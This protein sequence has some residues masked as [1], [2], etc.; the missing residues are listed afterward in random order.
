MTIEGELAQEA[1]MLQGGIY[2]RIVAK[3]KAEGTIDARYVYREYPK[4]LRISKGMQELPR[5]TEDCKGRTLTW[6]EHKE[7]FD[8]IVVNSEEEEERV[9]SGGKTSA[10]IEEERQELLRRCAAAGV[11]ADPSWSAVRL[12]RELGD[13]MDAPEPVDQMGA[14]KA[15]LAQLEEMS[16]MRSKIAALEAELSARPE[17]S[18]DMRA[19]LN[20]LG[21][22]TDGRWS[23][24]RLR[25][26]LDRATAPKS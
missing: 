17:D 18:D 6:T 10:Q 1:F 15:K 3:M 22:K 4:M 12:R 16:L 20:A 8:E 19:Q 11:R 14:L 21:V 9:L 2:A 25:E 13:K 23:A 24:S 7:V 5:S 26:E